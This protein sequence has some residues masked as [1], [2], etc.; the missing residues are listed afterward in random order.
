M[1]KNLITQTA[2]PAVAMPSCAVEVRDVHRAA[3][4]KAGRV[5]SHSWIRLR[6]VND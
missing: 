4:F 5:G 2:T 3:G 1:F 6:A